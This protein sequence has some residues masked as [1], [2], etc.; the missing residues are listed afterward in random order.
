VARVKSIVALSFSWWLFLNQKTSMFAYSTYDAF[1][2]EFP[3]A[4]R[5]NT[6]PS[7]NAL[8]FWGREPFKSAWM[9]QSW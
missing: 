6:S 1:W 7:T 4:L 9:L 2:S 3:S 8:A 5:L